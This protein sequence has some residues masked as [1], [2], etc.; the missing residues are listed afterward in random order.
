MHHISP[1]AAADREKDDEASRRYGIIHDT[2]LYQ[3][4]VGSVPHEAAL[5]PKLSPTGQYFNDVSIETESNAF[6]FA[7]S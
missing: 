3:T 6:D 1:F 4:D 2:A 5:L 7:Q